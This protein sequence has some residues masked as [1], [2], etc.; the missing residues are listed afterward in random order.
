MFEEN[1]KL[2]GKAHS[3]LMRSQVFLVVGAGGLGGFIANALVRL[4]AS[5]L[6]LVDD[7]CF[8][9]SNLNRQLFSDLKA[10]GKP[11]VNVIKEALEKINPNLHIDTF[12]AKVETLFDQPI[13][14][15]STVVFDAVDSVKTRLALEVFASEQNVP[16]VHGAIG[17]WYGQVG[18]IEPGTFLLKSLYGTKEKG[19]EKTLGS[20]TFTPPIIANLMVSECMKYLHQDPDVLVNKLLFMDLKTHTYHIMFDQTKT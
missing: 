15:K 13:I 16:L 2:L 7:D 12:N 20:P 19:V 6:I 3:D 14:K 9:E 1:H 5:H 10:I 8:D 4:G 17:G 18:I 11:K